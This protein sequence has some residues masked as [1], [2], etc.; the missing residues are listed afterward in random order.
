M[1]GNIDRPVCRRGPGIAWTGCFKKGSCIVKQREWGLGKIRAWALVLLLIAGFAT[2]P[3]VAAALSAT[4]LPDHVT[5]T[6]V[7]DARTTQTVAWRTDGDT[8][9][10]QV[11][12]CEMGPAA[13]SCPAYITVTAD[14][15]RMVTPEGSVQI[16]F[17][18]LTGLKSGTRYGYQV[19]TGS[20][21]TDFFSF[22]TAPARAGD[23]D[24]LV[25][26]DSQ[27]SDYNVWRATAQAGYRAAPN[28]AFFTNVGD[29][30]DVGQ[31]FREWEAWFAAAA[32]FVEKVP[33]MPVPGNHETYTP[34]GRFSL[35][36][37]FT[38]QFRLPSNGPDELKG[39][40]YSF[41]YG[42]V[43]FVVLDS[44]EGEEGR[45][46]PGM[47]EKQK[48]WLEKDLAATEK[49]WKIIFLHRPLYGNKPNGINENLRRAFA[50]IFDRYDASVV[51]T[52]HDHVYAKTWPLNAEG[53]AVQPGQG[54]VFVATGRSGTKTY[55][56]V[57]A[58]EWNE[59]FLNRTDEPI[60]LIVRIRGRIMSVQARTQSG[61]LIDEW[62]LEKTL[63][64]KE[65]P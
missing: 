14:V 17:A 46:V 43:H 22:S 58:K 37:F 40:V 62:S 50:A 32:G 10:G 27:S 12:F 49:T 7:Q 1:P 28:A 5:L 13:V 56:N 63:G 24:F 6:W 48:L 47:L 34:E 15:E 11:R 26:G 51:F 36:A 33:V 20:F 3:S 38:T 30:V 29:L 65:Q 57:A 44:Q 8:V 60:F 45:L 59:V 25:F 31:D 18:T 2:A 39:Q 9:D 35:P 52:A 54:T 41:D 53:T 23:F 4:T 61:E 64:K 55:S 42:D 16:H 19:G 21:W